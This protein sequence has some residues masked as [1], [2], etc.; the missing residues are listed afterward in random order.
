MIITNVRKSSLS[1]LQNLTGE[2][3]EVVMTS[4]KEKKLYHHFMKTLEVGHFFD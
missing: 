3:E 4:F 2:G 1:G